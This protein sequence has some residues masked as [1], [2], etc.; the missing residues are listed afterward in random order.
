MATRFSIARHARKQAFGHLY[1]MLD[2]KDNSQ[3]EEGRSED[4][5]GE[6]LNSNIESKIWTRQRR[7][8]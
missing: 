6:Q 3:L 2:S 7:A 8:L 1:A 5:S 4:L